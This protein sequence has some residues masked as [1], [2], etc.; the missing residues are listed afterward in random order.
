MGLTIEVADP[1]P[2]RQ[3]EG[4]SGHGLTGLEERV[5]LVGGTFAAGPV[6]DGFRAHAVLPIGGQP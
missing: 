5:R 1:G 4:G 2:A 6:G 3:S